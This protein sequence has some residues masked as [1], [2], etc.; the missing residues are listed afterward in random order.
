[1][2][3]IFVESLTKWPYFNSLQVINSYCDEVVFYKI[4]ELTCYLITS[5]NIN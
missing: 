5:S 4:L 3:I 1:M 2:N